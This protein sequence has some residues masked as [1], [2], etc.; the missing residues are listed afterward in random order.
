[1]PNLQGEGGQKKKYIYI[2][3]SVQDEQY[4]SGETVQVQY[5]DEF[6]VHSCGTVHMTVWLFI[7]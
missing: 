2:Y 3:I 7:E 6:I 4:E 5:C 1:M